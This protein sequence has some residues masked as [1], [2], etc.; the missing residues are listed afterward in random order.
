MTPLGTTSSTAPHSPSWPPRTAPPFCCSTTSSQGRVA[1]LLSD[2]IWLWSRGHEGGGPQAE[3]LRRIAHWLM[4]E[5]ALDEEALRATIDNGT[6]HIERRS[7]GQDG[8]PGR[9]DYG[10]RP[11]RR[12]HSAA[13]RRNPALATPPQPPHRP[14]SLASTKCLTGVHPNHLC[15][16]NRRQPA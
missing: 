8:P 12:H 13:A 14:P 7:T 3:L 9:D 16:R 5:P 6:I 15:C 1:L 11:V 4:K 10:N 2:Q